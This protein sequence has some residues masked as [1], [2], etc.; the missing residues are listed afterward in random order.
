MVMLS[1]LDTSGPNEGQNHLA[2]FVY[3]PKLE[4]IVMK[5]GLLQSRNLELCGHRDVLSSQTTH[6]YNTCLYGW[7]RSKED[8]TQTLSLLFHQVSNDLT[9]GET[10]TFVQE[11]SVQGVDLP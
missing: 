10:E 6:V 7:S 2:G 4:K 3:G 1:D 9:L 5:R 11:V 8:P